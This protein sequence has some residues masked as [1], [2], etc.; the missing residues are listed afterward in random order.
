MKWSGASALAAEVSLSMSSLFNSLLYEFS[1]CQIM[2][3]LTLGFSYRFQGGR[4]I[5][6]TGPALLVSN[7]ESF[8]DPIAIGLTTTRQLHYL[9]RKTLF[10]GVFGNFLRRV[11]CV[12]VDQEGVAKE[13]LKTVIA[14]LKE[15]KAVLVFPEGER[16]PNGEMLELKPGIQ[17][18]IRKTTPPIVP[19]GIAGA[20]GAYPRT[21]KIPRFS[22]LFM[23]A[24]R[25][26]FAVSVGAPLDGQAYAEKEPAQSLKDLQAAIQAMKDR[27]EKLRRKP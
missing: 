16:T 21:E 19:V 6:A 10:R 1:R 8:L 24:S 15:G 12:P 17:L 9:A 18:I 22:P 14:L 11:N 27:A 2:A 25:G 13:G 23:P 26:T 20:F 3:G 4:H 5:P 7:H